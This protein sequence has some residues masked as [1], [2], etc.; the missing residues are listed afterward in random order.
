MPC[1][2]AN[3][4]NRHDLDVGESTPPLSGFVNP[5]LSR[6]LSAGFVNPSTGWRL[7]A[8]SAGAAPRLPD[9][10]PPAWSLFAEWSFFAKWLLLA[11]WSLFP[12]WSFF[13]RGW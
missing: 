13:V 5:P 4:V 10:W 2:A 12:K 3:R 8:R 1:L 11:E 6:A 7:A 9:A